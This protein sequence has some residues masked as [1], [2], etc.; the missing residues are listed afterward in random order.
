MTARVLVGVGVV[1]AALFLI[2]LGTAP[3]LDP[4]EGVHAAVAWGMLRDGRWLIPHLAGLPYLDRPPLLH[5]LLAASFAALGPTEWAARLGSAVPAIGVAVLTAWIGTLLASAR[6][7]FLAGLIVAANPEMFVLGRM[8]GPDM[9]FVSLVLL[10]WAGFI[11]AYLGAGRRALLLFY[12]GLGL[13][14]LAKDLLGALGPLAAVALFLYIARE[15]RTWRVWTPWS[16]VVLCLAIAL[17]WYALMEWRYRGFL[18]HALVDHHLLGA[19]GPRAYPDEGVP[20]TAIEFLGVTAIGFFPWVLALPWAAWRAFRRPWDSPEARI[21]VLLGVWTVGTL[22]LCTFAPFAFAP[23]ALPAFPAM[24]LLVARLWDDALDRE[25]GTPSPRA[26]LLPALVGLA[27]AALL[28]ALLWQGALTLPA[29]ARAGLEALAPSTTARGPEAPVGALRP[30]GRLF[31]TAALVLGLGAAGVALGVWRR[32]GAIGL[33]GLIAVMLAFLPVTVEG[34]AVLARSRSV[35]VMTDAVAIRVRPGDLLAHEGAIESSASWLLSLDRPVI[36]V[37]GLRPGATPGAALPAA[38][39]L[40]W[41]G[42]ALDRVWRGER[43][44]LLLSVV[45]PARSV[46][47]AL[48]AGRVHLLVEGGGRWL[49]SNRPDS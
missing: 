23:C 45:P 40:S 18:R 7:G 32:R 49:Y 10:A 33:G 6:A 29:A 27:A 48:P 24:A 12:A 37:D 9:L 1:A 47:R 38:R 2:A 5:W 42:R 44:V 8:V 17:P 22:G 43:R 28:A 19:A 4:P 39:G 3:F 41:D 16:G 25:A 13:A 46:V 34:L 36:I 31:G 26:L 15:G 30:L 14:A 21:W 11:L 20:L 35:R